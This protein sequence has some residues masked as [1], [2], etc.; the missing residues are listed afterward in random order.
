MIAGALE[1][2]FYANMARIAKD[3]NDAKGIV[4]G[5]MNSIEKAVASAKAALGAL[6]VGLSAGY[7]V[8]LIKGSIDAADALN[9]MS[10]RVGISV[11]ALAKYELASRQS[12]TSMESISKGIKGLS[13][14]LVE[15][16]TALRA[17][18]ITAKDADGA[19][20]QV[21]DIFAAMPDGIEKTTLA[22]KLFGKSGMDLIPMLNLGS[23]GL[24][25]AAEKSA[26]YA[27]AMAALAPQADQFN[28]HLA[29]IAI[30]SKVAGLSMTDDL[31][32]ALNTIARN[33]A[34]A[35]QE[36]GALMAAW[37]AFGGV[38]SAVFTDNLLTPLAKV[39]KS[40]SSLKE[41]IESYNP[42]ALFGPNIAQ[43]RAELAQL[44]AERMAIEK[45]QAA[46]AKAAADAGKRQRDEMTE[47]LKA[48][49]KKI[50]DALGGGDAKK[51][52][53]EAL[54]KKA[55]E[56]IKT[57]E[58]ETAQIGLT[59]VQKKMVEA[60]LV[61]MTLKSE[62][63]QTAVMAAAAAWARKT[64]ELE[65]A[66]EAA[67]ENNR[68]AD[69]AL[70]EEERE[71]LAV[72]NGIKSLR[73]KI[74]ALEEESFALTA[75]AAQLREHIVLREME[76]SGL[77]KSSEAYA[78]MERRYRSALSANEM[79]KQ[80]KKGADEAAREWEKFADDVSR[81]LTDALMRGFDDGKPFAQNFLDSLQ[82]TFKTAVLKIAVQMVMDPIS[83]SLKGL[84][85]GASGAS[86]L[87]GNSGSITDTLSAGGSLYNLATGNVGGG[88][89]GALANSSLGSSMGL[90]TAYIDA[91]GIGEA[92]G[93]TALT[94]LGTAIPYIGMAIAAAS[95]LGMFEGDGPTERSASVHQWG[96]VN[97]YSGEYGHNS[98]IGGFTP[99]ANNQWFSG[100]MWPAQ[101]AFG[102]QLVAIDNKIAG[103][104]TP[105]QLAAVQAALQAD[106]PTSVGFGT[107]H[108]DW[109]NSGADEFIM[110][111]R[112]QI[113]LNTLQAGLG[114]L[115]AQGGITA[116]EVE[117]AVA[118]LN[119]VKQAEIDA[120][121]A[122][123]QA[124]AD[125][126]AAQKKIAE[127]WQRV[128]DGILETIAR[129]RGEI[130]GA[131]GS[132]AQAQAAFLIGTAAARA[133]DQGAAGMLPAL[134]QAVVDMGR[135]V[136]TTSTEQAMLTARTI[137]SLQGTV[138]S[139]AQ[140]GISVPA[141]DVGTNYVPRDMLARIHEGE[142][143]TPKRYNPAAGGAGGNGE[144][145]AEI[146]ELRTDVAGLRTEVAGLRTAAA[147]T[148][149][150]TRNL[151]TTL[152][153]VTR[154]GD[155][156]VT[157]P[158]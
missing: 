155:S 111:E 72:E 132:F 98:A 154:A 31:M 82:A 110:T 33:M 44:E 105:E 46:G 18:G 144:L 116:D 95:M 26:K 63:E 134:A 48:R 113:I 135:A 7:F 99:W 77:D 83:G 50:M 86:G 128:A 69:I 28:D 107:E 47:D 66:A 156:L 149:T 59:V 61:A 68:V 71:R 3:M 118:G 88:I 94:G 54:Q 141:F 80:A 90:S 57:L 153:R 53:Y 9:D 29:E 19:M 62:A 106:A 64:I 92:V 55:L 36:S 14:N 16:G 97:G 119:A 123:E 41:D 125:Q 30:S 22:V 131:P 127:G 130:G 109:R 42:L 39:N 129:L 133:G 43:M 45:A 25:E 20:K 74:V 8:S 13:G 34:L 145:I 85:G 2:Q 52:P 35:A 1:I 23:A 138:T 75:T 136:S 122:A 12:G 21:S 126:L 58:K 146:R 56:Y 24:G 108:T 143:V 150:S 6:G 151:D 102:D 49:I 89:Y 79:A 152:T 157:T 117:N 17:A 78:E 27:A 96:N 104:I 147:A 70:D 51:D 10:Q 91:L 148:A 15:H 67:R 32:P 114:D 84:L 60:S 65:L 11:A 87:F 4:G 103:A 137:A 140:F 142:A 37:V 120:A 139:M 115:A 124:A 81:S 101:K 73:E 40:I 93:G 112:Y 100:D 5:A 38:A 158:A 121:A 76:K